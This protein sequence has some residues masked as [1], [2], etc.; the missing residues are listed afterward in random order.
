M[1]TIIHLLVY[2]D[3]NGQPAGF[4]I[5]LVKAA[6]QAMNYD[7]V[8]DLESWDLAR[9]ALIKNEADVI[10]GMFYS[11]ERDQK[12]S[13]STA[14]SI[15][16]GDIFCRRENRIKSIDYLKG[17]TV[18]VQKSDIVYEYLSELDLDLTYVEVDTVGEALQ[19]IDK[20]EY[21]YA[22]LLKPTAHYIMDSQNYEHLVSNG[23]LIAPKKYCFA[24]KQGNEEI[25][26]LLNGGLHVL[27][28]TGQ[29]QEIYD[30]WLGVYEEKTFF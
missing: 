23:L 14:H 21:A 26:Y 1:T 20:E 6:A 3:E 16:T 28:S 2:L 8:F 18:V 10:S 25:I 13:F 24:A 12:F 30:K 19:L 22:A 7:V 15:A 5:D 29:Y 9:D 17:K 27:K 11:E 4:N